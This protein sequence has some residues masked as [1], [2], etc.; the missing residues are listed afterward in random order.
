MKRKYF[1]F[2]IDGTLTDDATHR[3][4]PSAEETLR[5]LREAGHFTAVATG[6]MHYKTKAFTDTIGIHNLVCAG[7]GCL[8]VEDEIIDQ[9]YLDKE[10]AL[11]FL[12]HC[13]EEGIGWLITPE[14]NDQV[15]MRDFRF[16]EQAGRRREL[17]T[18]LVDRE[19]DPSALSGIMKIYAAVPKGEEYKYPWLDLLGH[20]RLS[21]TYLVIQYDKKKEGILRMMEYL[22]GDATDVVVFGDAE[23]DLVMFDPRWTSIA[24]G[25]GVPALKE[26][27]DYV[28]AANTDD[29]IKK[30]CE[31]FGWISQ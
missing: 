1:F 20:L 8:V 7:G 28:T 4:V 6:R 16:L 3:I 25:N 12:R 13:D 21:D 5:R 29:G 27:A 15:I 10:K 31:H 11:E 30:A 14:D 17:T 18:Y 24:M 2:D 23:N 19:L 22:Q 9:Q 26:K